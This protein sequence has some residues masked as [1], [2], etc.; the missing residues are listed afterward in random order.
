MNTKPDVLETGEPRACV[1]WSVAVESQACQSC[2]NMTIAFTGNTG[3]KRCAD[4]P[5]WKVSKEF[6]A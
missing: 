1:V 3:D 4:C 2:W 6:S 5:R